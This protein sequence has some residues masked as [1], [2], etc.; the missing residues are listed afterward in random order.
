MD[1]NILW[2]TIL[3]L[4]AFVAPSLAFADGGSAFDTYIAQA[5]AL[6]KD[7]DFTGALA[8]YNKALPVAQSGNDKGKVLHGMALCHRRLRQYNEA[9]EQFSKVL[10]VEDDRHAWYHHGS[11]QIHIGLSYKDMAE[12]KRAIEEF[13]KVGS[14]PT[15]GVFKSR[16]LLETAYCL[17][18]LSRNPSLPEGEREQ[19]A[20]QAKQAYIR[21]LT[22]TAEDGYPLYLRRAYAQI[23]PNDFE[24]KAAYDVFLDTLIDQLAR[25]RR[26]KSQE[27]MEFL[28][29]VISNGG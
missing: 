17:E 9:I 10:E 23:S 1:K 6:E 15:T 19:Y 22:E 4:A 8:Q 5:E 28:N 24:S 12:H 21:V 29:S 7:R 13:E 18:A 2:V 14:L 25:N 20:K 26:M 3:F 11:A 27:D 16:A